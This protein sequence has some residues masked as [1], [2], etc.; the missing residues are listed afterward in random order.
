MKDLAAKGCRLCGHSC[1]V[2]RRKGRVGRCGAGVD[3]GFA[4]AVIHYGEEPPLS[5]LSPRDGGSGAIFFSRC[6]L[7]CAFCQNWQISQT[8]GGGVDIE[9]NELANIMLDLQQAGAYNVN[10]VSPTPYVVEIALALSLAKSQGLTIPIVYNSGGY[11]SLRALA[12][13]DGLV[14]VYLPDAK[15]GQNPLLAPGDPDSVA[16]R[17]FGA[18]DYATVN[19]IALKEMLRQ[20]GHLALDSRGLATRGLLVRHLVLPDDLARTTLVLPWVAENLGVETCISLM[21]QYHPNHRVRSDDLR[22]F[23]EFP[24]LTRPLSV[25]EYD[26]AVALAWEL[27]LENSFIQ[28]LAAATLYRPN[29]NKPNAFN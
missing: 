24:G 15:I 29:F 12:I 3:V 20:V 19:Q 26:A 6:N 17:L 27:G 25:R 1:L 11:D 7:A 22:E 13:M 16:M 2:D 28:D 21:A 23:R 5:G 18:G 4:Q 10:L 14:D 8:E 9:V